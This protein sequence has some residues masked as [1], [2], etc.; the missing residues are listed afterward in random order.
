MGDVWIETTESCPDCRAEKHFLKKHP[1]VWKKEAINE[2]EFETPY[3]PKPWCDCD[4]FSGTV[5]SR[6][7]AYEPEAGTMLVVN[8][9]PV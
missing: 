8:E 2:C 9:V 5:R 7:R 6:I 3:Q 1:N 4:A